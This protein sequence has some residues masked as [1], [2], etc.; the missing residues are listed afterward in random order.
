MF[1]LSFLADTA[2]V[3][4]GASAASTPE[5]GLIGALL[6][7]LF[8]FIVFY[9]LILR[10]QQ[11]KMKEHQALISGVRRGDKIVTSGGILGKV[12]KVNT[13][14]S[15]AD[16]EIAE[17]VEVEVLISTIVNILNKSQVVNDNAKEKSDKK[18]AK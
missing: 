11:R 4:V 13:D 14:T 5:G 9:F 18:K 15:T 8:I 3:A 7:F 2:S 1:N 10:P 16:V 12:T 6:P 17:G